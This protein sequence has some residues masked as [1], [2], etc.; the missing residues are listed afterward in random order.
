MQ[1]S[2]ASIAT[3]PKQQPRADLGIHGNITSHLEVMIEPGSRGSRVFFFF[4]LFFVCSSSGGHKEQSGRRHFSPNDPDE[5]CRGGSSPSSQV[6]AN[7]NAKMDPR[8]IIIKHYGVEKKKLRCCS[9][10][11]SM[12]LHTKQWPQN[13][14]DDDA[15][16]VIIHRA[17]FS[18]VLRRGFFLKQSFLQKAGEKICQSLF[19]FFKQCRFP[20]PAV[21]RIFFWQFWTFSGFFTY[22]AEG[23][24]AAAMIFFPTGLTK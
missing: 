14:G 24:R 20:L 3:A 13:E 5:L 17:L 22:K 6:A 19:T 15:I 16:I 2:S 11:C 7:N 9:C 21:W 12:I 10:C 18:I 4:S 8:P 23:A 1:H